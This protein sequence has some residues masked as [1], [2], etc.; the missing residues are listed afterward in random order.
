MYYETNVY[1][2]AG[3]VKKI[4][5]DSVLVLQ[6]LTSRGRVLLAA[7]C[8]GMGGME[9]GECASGYVTEELIAWFY[10]GL[11]YA[12]GKKKP[13]WVIRRSLERKVYQMQ[14]R[15]QDYARKRK[16]FMGTTMSVLVLWEKRYFIWHL[17]DS[18][19]YWMKGRSYMGKRSKSAQK[20]CTLK[21]ITEDH[22]QGKNRLTKCV[23]NCGFFVPDFK[24]GIVRRREAFLLCSDGFWNELQEEELRE[25]LQ[26]ERMTEETSERRLKE[27]AD[28]VMRR[29]E[30][31]NLSAVYIKCL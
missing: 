17:G 18:R 2:N 12:I 21:Q 24:T 1:W 16:I 7:V 28:A 22:V 8:D 13:L 30:K 4:N 11:L 15:M 3:A 25:V 31:D 19:I 23:G 27:L 9:E 10:D 26:P 29:G 5:Q 14:N 20:K 6:A